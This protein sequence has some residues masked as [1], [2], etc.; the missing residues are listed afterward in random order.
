MS[1]P[2]YKVYLGRPKE[3]WYQLSKDEQD[4]L[5]AEELKARVYFK[6]LIMCDATAF[7]NEWAFFGVE[8][9]PDVESLNMA[10]EVERGSNWRRYVEGV[11]V[12]G[13]KAEM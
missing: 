1:G 13:T 9:Y 7:S 4:A 3:A 8:E 6:P 10:A 2:I 11:S 12:L 5:L